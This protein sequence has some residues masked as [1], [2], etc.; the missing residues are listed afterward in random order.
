MAERV[1]IATLDIDEQGAV[2]S[3]KAVEQQVGSLEK[4]TRTTADVFTARMFNM[5]NAA[6]AFLGTFTIAGGV[7]AFKSFLTSIVESQENFKRFSETAAAT[8]KSLFKMVGD[9]TGLNQALGDMATILERINAMNAGD[10]EPG[11]L[12]ILW[13][14]LWGQT[15][16]GRVEAIINRVAQAAA[17]G[18][19]Q[20]PPA[21]AGIGN[22]GYDPDAPQKARDAAAK[23]FAEQKQAIL[24]GAQSLSD[25]NLAA[26]EAGKL[27]RELYESSIMAA[28]GF[29]KLD[30]KIEETNI[31]EEALVNPDKWQKF[32][33]AF[34]DAIN[35]MVPDLTLVGAAINSAQ[36]AIDGMSS[37]L[38]QGF[39]E[40]GLT[41]KKI[42]SGILEA[43]GQMLIYLGSAAVIKGIFTYNAAE[44]AAG[45]AAIAIGGAALALSSRW[46]AGSEGVAPGLGG[47]GFAASPAIAGG[48]NTYNITNIIEG[49]GNPDAVARSV[50]K[51]IKRATA[52]G[53]GG[54]AI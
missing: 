18:T 49:S 42:I 14:F 37:A 35:E 8:Q 2:R 36:A 53:A 43:V 52:D 38:I 16:I 54:G 40:G 34:K 23:T 31:D 30:E 6:T 19:T 5:K 20:G 13:K 47:N 48:G 45:A 50:V 11:K 33:T 17:V 27:N 41:F 39:K 51:Y 1:V 10:S 21:P 3:V 4:Q 15:D 44:A 7:L 32:K 24:E 28:S 25:Y 26:L 12:G 46:G 29:E 9:M 22:Y